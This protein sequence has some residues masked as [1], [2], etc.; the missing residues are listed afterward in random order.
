LAGLKEKVKHDA[1]LWADLVNISGGKLE[2]SKCSVHYLTFD[3][4]PDGTPQVNLDRQPS[5]ELIDPLTQTGIGLKS[6]NSTQPHKTL[7]HWKAPAGNARKQLRTICDKVRVINL[8][9]ATSSVSQY[10]AQLAYHAITVS[11]LRYVLPQCHFPLAAKCGFSSR[12]PHA[13][14]FATREYA[15]GGF[16]HWDVIQGE[17]QILLFLKHWRTDTALAAALQIDLAWCQ[18]QSGIS[19]SI[20]VNTTRNLPYL[21]ARWIPSVRA[22]LSQ[23]RVRIHIER[24]F[25][26]PPECTNEGYLMKIAQDNPQLTNH[27]I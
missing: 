22:S 19:Q 11:T 16:V 2:L 24:K 13:L 5:V 17:G 3:F 4:D 27:N 12:T 6:L 18:W 20:L 15:G 8:R 26:V 7:G 14:L 10:G 1:Q 23:F 21:E 9:I 25:I